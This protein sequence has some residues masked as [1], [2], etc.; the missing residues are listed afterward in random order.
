MEN[1]SMNP[2][3][4]TPH[5]ALGMLAL[6]LTIPAALVAYNAGLSQGLAEVAAGPGNI[7]PPP[8][9]YA[10]HRPWGAVWPLFPL[11]F[12]FFWGVVAR[13]FW[14]GWGP[15]RYWHHGYGADDR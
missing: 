11:M 1:T 7:T 4:S 12:I 6:P 13:A 8:Y 3:S 10:G 2:R 14:W 5:W 15:R 9:A